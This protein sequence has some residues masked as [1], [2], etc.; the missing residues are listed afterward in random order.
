MVSGGRIVVS[1]VE[2]VERVEGI[3]GLGDWGILTGFTGLGFSHAEAQRGGERRG[4]WGV[5]T[6]RTE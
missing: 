5:V 4:Y 1:R 2:R 6:S 3:G